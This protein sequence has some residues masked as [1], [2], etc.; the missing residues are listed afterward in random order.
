MTSLPRV[1][2]STMRQF[3]ARS[4]SV[5][6]TSR[7][8][9]PESHGLPETERRGY[10]CPLR[11]KFSRPCPRLY[12]W[13]EGPAK[14][15]RK[16]V[17]PTFLKRAFLSPIPFGPTRAFLIILTTGDFGSFARVRPR[18]SCGYSNSE[19]QSQLRFNSQALNS[20]GSSEFSEPSST[21]SQVQQE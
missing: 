5:M 13:Q 10:I 18:K 16:I 9:N 3:Q 12:F 17:R 19:Y 7:V 21:G 1:V 4:K 15:A 2:N 20:Q 8:R 11:G 6:T 14:L